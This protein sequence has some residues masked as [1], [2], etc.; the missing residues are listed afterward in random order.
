MTNSMTNLLAA[1][2]TLS[3]GGG[4]VESQRALHG[5]LMEI[6]LGEEA[7]ARNIAET[8]R[9]RRRLEGQIMEE[10]EDAD[11]RRKK[12]RLG[13]DGKPWRSRNRRDS[14]ALKRDQQVEEF[15]RE[16]RLDVYDVPSDQPEYATNMDDDEMAADDRIAEEF[17]R[18]FMDAMSQRH[19]R[20]R[21]AVNATA[22]P[23]ARNQDSEILKGPKLGGSRNARAAMRE[24][25]LREQEQ[26]KRR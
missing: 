3:V 17:R 14:D 1:D 15:L 23:S 26:Q 25:L 19:R 21:P 18:D 13:P 7:R 5:K 9:A 8:E 20:R 4:K 24:K 22:R 12:V 2:P 11:G 16:N 10:E 6:D